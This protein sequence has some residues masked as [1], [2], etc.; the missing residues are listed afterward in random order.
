MLPSITFRLY[1]TRQV[2]IKFFFKEIFSVN[3]FFLGHGLN[4]RGEVYEVDEKVLK[5]LDYLEDHPNYYVREQ[6]D[7]QRVDAP[8]QATEKVWIY[9]I[10]SFKKELLN[11]PFFES[12]SNNGSHGLKYVER[13]LRDETTDHKTELLPQNNQE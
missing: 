11:R 8:D 1:C 7:V 4:V 6:Y 5:N 12:Y 2:R 3:R 9:M 10:K 13:Y